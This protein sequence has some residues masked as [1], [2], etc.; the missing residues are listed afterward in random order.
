VKKAKRILC[1]ED[2]PDMCE[3][4]ATV[5]DGYQITSAHSMADALRQA[6]ESQPD[7]YLLDYHLPDG[8]GFELCL[9]LRNFD[10]QTPI[11]FFSGTK[12]ITDS[13]VKNIGAQGFISKQSENFINEL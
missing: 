12:A 3:L 11:L 8:T 6:A 9:L 1:V 2:S 7:L 10:E 5:L 13:Q 4:V